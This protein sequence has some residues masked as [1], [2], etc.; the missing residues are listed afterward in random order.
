V[1]LAIPS[2]ALISL[3][4]GYYAH[5]YLAGKKVVEK[6]A[7]L[8]LQDEKQRIVDAISRS[9]ELPSGESPI[10]AAVTDVEKLR[11]QSFFPDAQ[12]DDQLI[13]YSDA[14]KAIV[15]RLSSEKIVDI[16][17]FLE[18]E[19]EKI[20]KVG[21]EL[22]SDQIAVANVPAEN[23]T[24]KV[25]AE[26]DV[27]VQEEEK[28]VR[29][30]IYNGT[31]NKGVSEK[32]AEVINSANLDVNVVIKTNAKGDYGKTMVIDLIG[33]NAEL[34]TNIAGSIGGNVSTSFPQ[35][36]P[37]PEADVLVIGGEK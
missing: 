25:L 2:V 16:I 21:K 8:S 26:T 7:S 20:V 22:S 19:E 31:K 14:K 34:V 37:M 23:G 28:K 15:Y 27:Q 11:D 1:S 36:E 29:V 6:S 30:A 10:V 4:F 33:N 32:L 5:N 9:M 18:K 3:F 12:V 13:M 24:E 17:P 35:G